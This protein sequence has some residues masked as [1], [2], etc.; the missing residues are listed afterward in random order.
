MSV[1]TISP[2]LSLP[3]IRELPES[4]TGYYSSA[5]LLGFKCLCEKCQ[6]TGDALLRSNRRLEAVR[7]LK[8]D[9]IPAL[10][11]LRELLHTEQLAT[12]TL[13]SSPKRGE[14]V[15]DVERL[16]QPTIAQLESCP[17]GDK[18]IVMATIHWLLKMV[19]FVLLL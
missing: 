19:G 16:I 10:V 4:E 6:L 2:I 7:G 11:L 14:Y 18:N 13:V 5:K 12:Y 8:L 15:M 1:T 9:S 3:A 17:R